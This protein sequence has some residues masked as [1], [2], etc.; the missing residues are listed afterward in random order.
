MREKVGIRE[1]RDR[2][3]A[4]MRRVRAGEAIEITHD[5]KPVALLTP[6]PADRIERLV[7]GGDVSAGTPLSRPPQRFPVTGPLTAGQAL[8]EDRAEA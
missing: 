2:L 3:T 4:V 5:G 6:L 1:L 8:E 7:A